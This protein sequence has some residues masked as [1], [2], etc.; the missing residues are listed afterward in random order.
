MQ[1]DLKQLYKEQ[2]GLSAYCHPNQKRS[3]ISK[4]YVEWLEKNYNYGL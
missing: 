4:E 2:T 1:Q 3:L